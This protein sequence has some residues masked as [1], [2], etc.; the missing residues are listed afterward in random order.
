MGGCV[1]VSDAFVLESVKAGRGR[2]TGQLQNN[3]QMRSN[4]MRI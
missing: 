1:C 3:M 2:Y 4:E